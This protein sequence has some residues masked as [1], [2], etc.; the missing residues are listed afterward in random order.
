MTTNP[1]TVKAAFAK[2]KVFVFDCD[3]V[4]WRGGHLLPRVPEMLEMLTARGKKF[5]FVTNNSTRSRAEN[6]K[7]FHK[8]GLTF[9]KEEDILTSAFAAAA[10]LEQEIK[11]PRD[12]KVYVVGQHGII[13][14]LALLG[15]EGIGGPAHSDMRVDPEGRMNVDASVGAVVVG[16]DFEVN[17]YKLSY[18]SM[19]I[20]HNEGCHFVA[21]NTDALAHLNPDEEHPGGGTMV[22][23]VQHAT[24][25]KP[26][27]AGKP[28]MFLVSYLTHKF[29]VE[30]NEMCMVGDR[31]D[32]DILFGKR[33]GMET[34]LVM[35]GVT[36]PAILAQADEEHTPDMVLES[37]ADF[38]AC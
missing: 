1:E 10:L 26:V 34:A 22:A 11:L 15:Y 32:T 4:I 20:R 25:R 36:T 14:E 16:Y 38:L 5:V 24:G 29:D 31:L 13:D 19:C 35:S 17:Y 33:S 27:V 9:V 37:V 18:A 23:A 7:K 30:L 3:G 8:L 6:V 21:T 2:T 28:S 12:R